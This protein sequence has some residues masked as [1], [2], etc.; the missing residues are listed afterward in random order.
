MSIDR[1][2]NQVPDTEFQIDRKHRFEAL[3]F[4]KKH[5]RDILD[6]FLPLGKHTL[7]A[8]ES[9]ELTPIEVARIG[10]EIRN[11]VEWTAWS[12]KTAFPPVKKDAAIGVSLGQCLVTSRF[13][14]DYFINSKLAEVRVLRDDG[15]EVGDHIVLTLN[16]N[17]GQ[18]VLDLTPDQPLARGDVPSDLKGLDWRFKVSIYPLFDPNCPYKIKRFQS[19]QELATK[20]SQP[21]EHTRLLK[22]MMSFIKLSP[23]ISGLER[24]ASTVDREKMLSFDDVKVQSLFNVFSQDA[25]DDNLRLN[26][27]IINDNPLLPRPA[28]LW[29]A[30]GLTGHSLAYSI[31]AGFVREIYYFNNDSI[32]IFNVSGSLNNKKELF[33]INNI[34]QSEKTVPLISRPPLWTYIKRR[35]LSGPIFVDT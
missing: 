30:S 29:E 23:Y 35:G 27:G 28:W 15:V 14:A 17:E 25:Q 5:T 7:A 9:S 20:A 2:N 11:E 1:E 18:H 10:L 22:E 31:D 12:D 16:T 26:I 3:K 13:A 8:V 21:L 34:M 6:H 33:E 4:G 24:Y 19:D 32:T